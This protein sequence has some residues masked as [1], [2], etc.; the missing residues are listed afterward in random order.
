MKNLV[1]RLFL[2]VRLFVSAVLVTATL[3]VLAQVASTAAAPRIGVEI[4][5]NAK[6][7]LPNSKLPRAQAQYDGGRVAAST[8]LQGISI[9]FNRT[10]G[11]EAALKAL[12]AAQQTPGSPQ[13]HQWLTPEQFASQ[14]GM[15]DSDI[16]KVENWLEQQGFSI[17]SVARGKNVLRFT[18]TVGQVEAAFATEMHNYNVPTLKGVVKHFAPST[19]LSVPSAIAGMVEGVRNLD[20]FRPRSHAVK[21]GRVKPNFTQDL[22]G[23]Q[24]VF[25]APGDIFLQYD[26]QNEYNASFKGTGQSIAIVGQSQ[27]QVSDLDAFWTAAGIT[28][29]DPEMD[30]VAGT[31]DPTP[32]P[33]GDE[34]ESDLDLEWSGAIAQGAN[35]HFVF[36]GS[37]Q[38]YGAFDSIQYAIDNKIGTIISSSYGA[39]ETSLGGQTLETILEQAATQGQTVLSA[40]GDDGSTDCFEDTGLTTA[41][42]E[43]LA[44]DYPASSPNV[45]A[46]GGTEVSQANAAYLTAGSGYWE[47]A[48]AS[49]PQVTSLQKVVPE[50]AWN[51]DLICLQGLQQAPTSGQSPVCAGGGGASALFPKPS[52]QTALTPAD[53]HRDVPDLSLDAALADPGYLFCTSDQSFWQQGQVASC[54]SGFLDGATG[55][56]T[57]AGGTSFATPIFAGMLALINQQ[58]GYTNG[59]GPINPTLYTLASNSGTYASAFRDI[60]TGDNKCDST[61]TYC[62]SQGESEFSAGTGYD[63]ATG[64]GTVDLFNLAAAWPVNPATPP[65]LIAT[66]TTVT[67]SN[68]TPAVG[69]S[70]SFT[71][72]VTANGSA[73]S[74]GTVTITVDPGTN[75]TSTATGTLVNGAYVFTTSLATTGTNVVLVN[76][77]G[78]STYA[79]SSGQVSVDVP[80]PVSGKGTIAM[81]ATNLTVSQGSSGSSTITVTPAGGYTGTVQISFDTSNDTALQNMCYEFTT[82]TSSGDGT[83]AV[84]GTAAVTTQLTFDTNAADCATTAAVAKTGK[85]QLRSIHRT[86]ASNS[87]PDHGGLKTTSAGL[88]LA[89]LLLA[90]FLGRSSRKFRNLA[91]LLLMA[92]AGLAISAC[93]GGSNSTTVSNPPKGSYT[94]TLTGQDTSTATITATTTFTFVID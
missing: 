2:P 10:V 33:D 24:L 39:C 60:T 31:G 25:F 12:M 42:Q 80:T 7:A 46:V 51:E 14:F 3:P 67:A 93:G 4:N 11:Q 47:E 78:D 73:I 23:T 63:Q 84:T 83:V 17:D 6:T 53:G 86:S 54:N 89:G 76:Y 36:T 22:G 68:S 32:Q 70:D 48:T 28:R 8:R 81:S 21:R 56:A 72:S 37:N 74:S 1:Q 34:A 49:S 5:G 9:Y 50:Q 26:I 29:S 91:C 59:Q 57:A 13:Y 90:G 43:A 71:I 27:V 16:A 19:A 66:T 88:A 75:A 87:S 52:Y 45:T 44:V 65:V 85:H 94:V 64:L 69:A 30:I 77:A 35:L 61:N 15:A 40:A 55:D 20:D 58:Q 41:Q 38:S 18:G 62:S 82:T 79:A 92:A